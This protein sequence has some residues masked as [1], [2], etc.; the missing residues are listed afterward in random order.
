[1]AVARSER[2][3]RGKKRCGGAPLHRGREKMRKR[4][5]GKEGKDWERKERL[6]N[7]FRA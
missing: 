7:A 1:M 4:R 2:G 5:K 6:M 3:K